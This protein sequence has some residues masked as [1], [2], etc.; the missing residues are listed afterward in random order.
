MRPQ[1]ARDADEWVRR[2]GDRAVPAGTVRHLD[3]QRVH[4]SMWRTPEMPRGFLPQDGV[5]ARRGWLSAPQ[6]K[7]VDPDNL[8]GTKI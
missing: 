1:G 6:R 8:F 7:G 5:P 3:G 2:D 4:P